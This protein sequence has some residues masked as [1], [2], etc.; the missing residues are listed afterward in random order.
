[1]YVK[2]QDSIILELVLTEFVMRKPLQ[3]KGLVV[4]ATVM[5]STS[6]WSIENNKSIKANT[7][8]D[9]KNVFE[10]K[11]T[12][13]K[14]KVN[15]D[16]LKGSFFDKVGIEYQIDPLLLYC[17][18]LLESGSSF[19]NMISPTPLVIRFDGHAEFF[20][21]KEKAIA[22]LNEVL[23]K[24]T[25]VDVGLIQRNLYWHPTRSPER[26]FDAMEALR[27]MARQLK[28]TMASTN[29]L[30]LGIG[31][32]H[33]WTDEV[34]ARSYGRRVLTMYQNLSSHNNY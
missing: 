23:A 27:W 12:A 25:N 20:E 2:L 17:V 11:E 16:F 8:S 9:E 3:I 1:M 5:F 13:S 14:K 28:E 30:A 21:T 29:D 34:R 26:M 7:A 33:I 31:R 4:L 10:S 19:N 15:P 32:Y 24:T 18:T 22:R 6:C